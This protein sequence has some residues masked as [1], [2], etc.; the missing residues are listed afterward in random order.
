MKRIVIIHTNFVSRDLLMRLFAENCPGVQV[1]NIVDDSLLDEVSV[2]GQVTP[3]VQRRMNAYA[4]Q[5]ASLGPVLIFC[6]CSSVGEAFDNAC[7]ELS[8]KTLR[9]D[10][11][12]AEKAAELCPDKGGIAVVATVKSTVGPSVRLVEQKAAGAGK[13]INVVPLLIDG[14]LDILVKENNRAKH[15]ELVMH[16][17]K[18]ACARYDVIVL[19]QASM[20]EISQKMQDLGRP[21]LAS[22][23]LAV[24]AAKNLIG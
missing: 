4:E 12:M 14:A 7:E 20:Y 2:A 1:S 16:R 6:Q 9:I 11:P 17:V 8:I 18:D 13:K 10:A 19:A 23:V 3:G 22:P 15:D 24:L 21:V 5:A